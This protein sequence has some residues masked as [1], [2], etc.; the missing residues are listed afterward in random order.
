MN[1]FSPERLHEVLAAMAWE[2]LP[3]HTDI[4]THL[5]TMS[6]ILHDPK[7][8]RELQA[9]VR[10]RPRPTI[11]CLCGS[12]RFWKEYIEANQRETAAG[13]IVLTVGFFV[14]LDPNPGV[15]GAY[16][17]LSNADKAKLDELHLRKI[18]MA[19]EVLILN[20]GGYMGESTRAELEYAKA[21]GKRIRT[22]EPLKPDGL[23]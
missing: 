1:K 15:V 13:N 10:E 7:Q 17:A 19:D 6:N 4:E 8:Y 21:H 23:A 14:H 16:A 12:T 11:V 2:Q 22:L 3:E 9:R 20:R 18:D 5:L